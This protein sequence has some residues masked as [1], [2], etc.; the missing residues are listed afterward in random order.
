MQCKCDKNVLI[1]GRHC[2][3]VTYISTRKLMKTSNAQMHVTVIYHIKCFKHFSERVFA[4]GRI[5]PS[6]RQIIPVCGTPTSTTGSV[7]LVA[8]PSCACSPYCVTRVRRI[9]CPL[10][11]CCP[12]R[13]IGVNIP[14]YTMSSGI[15]Q[16]LSNIYVYIYLYN[17]NLVADLEVRTHR[18]WCNI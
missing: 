10:D 4:Q 13:I 9:F 11:T 17:R 1:I 7:V 2:S 16:E 14:L 6:G 3:I 18:E 5:L 12:I 15:Q 8:A